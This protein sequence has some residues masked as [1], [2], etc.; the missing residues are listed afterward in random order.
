MKRA[1]LLAIRHQPPGPL[2]PGGPRHARSG[3]SSG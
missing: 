1:A 2:R 3:K